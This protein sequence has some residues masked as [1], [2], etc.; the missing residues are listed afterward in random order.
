[1]CQFAFE[2]IH[3]PH[4]H[5]IHNFESLLTSVTFADHFRWIKKLMAFAHARNRMATE[6]SF[7]TTFE[8]ALF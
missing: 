5:C 1:M 8:D 4:K 2:P 6:S 7:D 3:L